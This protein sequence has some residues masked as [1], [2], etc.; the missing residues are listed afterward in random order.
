MTIADTYSGQERRKRDRSVGIQL[1]RRQKQSVDKASDRRSSSDNGFDI[2]G[3]LELHLDDVPTRRGMITLLETWLQVA[4]DSLSERDENY[5]RA[6]T[7][8]I[9]VMTAAPDPLVGIARL[10]RTEE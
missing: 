2:A 6:V 3:A 7:H 1:R 4:N 9:A 10:Q 8:A 5:V